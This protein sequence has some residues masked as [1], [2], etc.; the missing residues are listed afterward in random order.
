[1]A[2]PCIRRSTVHHRTLLDTVTCS[3][4]IAVFTE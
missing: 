4:T 3:A 1:M 2:V